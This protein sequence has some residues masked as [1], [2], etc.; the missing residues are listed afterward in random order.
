[1]QSGMLSALCT[2]LGI[3]L[4]IVGITTSRSHILIPSTWKFLA[5]ET[6]QCGLERVLKRDDTLNY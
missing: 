2:I 4:M 6:L 5:K 1:M 3:I